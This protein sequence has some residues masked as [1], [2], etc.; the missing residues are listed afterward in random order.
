MQATAAGSGSKASQSAASRRTLY[1][2]R[3]HTEGW[4]RVESLPPAQAELERVDKHNKLQGFQLAAH[5]RLGSRPPT[6]LNGYPVVLALLAYQ[7]QQVLYETV[8]RAY[9]HSED[10]EKAA[11]DEVC[12][13][14]AVYVMCAAA[15]LA[16]QVA[17]PLARGRQ[18][19]RT[20]SG[21][22][23]DNVPG[24]SKPHKDTGDNSDESSLARG[25][26][27]CR[28]VVRI[29]TGEPPADGSH[30]QLGGF[31]LTFSQAAAGGG[32]VLNLTVSGVLA[33]TKHALGKG[34]PFFHQVAVE[35]PGII[36]FLFELWPEN[37]LPRKKG[38]FRLKLEA[39]QQAQPPAAPL[40]PPPD[41]LADLL[42]QG[43]AAVQLQTSGPSP[44][45][46]NH[47]AAGATVFMLE[48]RWKRGARGA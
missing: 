39:F 13:K 47:S 3:W 28:V 31:A 18:R 15:T 5:M 45:L 2:T 12:G 25:E 6:E 9:A 30:Q 7:N 41:Q 36:S 8:G 32:V 37:K 14:W 26:C 10:L 19:L 34:S 24:V 46:H 20:L 21:Q 1:G 4:R 33:A 44:R 42:P 48:G 16:E 22:A 29:S 17:A 11:A 40:L 23:I 38:F 43:P 27:A 35:Q